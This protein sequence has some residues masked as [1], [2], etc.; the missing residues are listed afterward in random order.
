MKVTNKEIAARFAAAKA[1]LWDGAL[2]EVRG[3]TSTTYICWAIDRATVSPRDPVRRACKKIISDRLDGK[4]TL[5]EWLAHKNFADWILTRKKL[6]TVDQNLKL[7]ITRHAWLDSLIE[8]F[9]A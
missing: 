3:S 1:H 7:Q 4:G 9:S 5:Q 2:D 6:S 8:E